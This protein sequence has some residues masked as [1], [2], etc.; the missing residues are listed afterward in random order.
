MKTALAIISV[1]LVFLPVVRLPEETKW[2]ETMHL[3]IG[4][5][6]ILLALLFVLTIT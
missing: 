5:S 2:P 6:W 1:L 4:I 3:A